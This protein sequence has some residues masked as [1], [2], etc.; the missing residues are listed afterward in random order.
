MATSH[1]K[2]SEPIKAVEPVRG[3]NTSHGHEALP[4]HARPLEDVTRTFVPGEQLRVNIERDRGMEEGMAAQSFNSLDPCCF[5]ISAGGEVGA[6]QL[7]QRGKEHVMMFNYSWK[8]EGIQYKKNQQAQARLLQGYYYVYWSIGGYM[9][10][11]MLKSVYA[12]LTVISLGS[13]ELSL[14][15]FVPMKTFFFYMVDWAIYNRE[16][17]AGTCLRITKRRG[18]SIAQF[19]WNAHSSCL[20]NGYDYLKVMKVQISGPEA[21]Q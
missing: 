2:V 16:M 10:T 19:Q 5:R 14:Y 9:S 17:K 8:R 18:W 7:L 11:D 21:L 15:V 4:H 1:T 3:P 20:F 6:A 13:Y 12:F